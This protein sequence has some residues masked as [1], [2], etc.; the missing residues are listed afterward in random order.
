MLL[1]HDWSGKAEGGY[2]S[3]LTIDLNNSGD[4]CTHDWFSDK[5]YQLLP[6]GFLKNKVCDYAKSCSSKEEGSATAVELMFEAS[7]YGQQKK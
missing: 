2:M 3:A 6:S 1:S 5:R 7:R 4:V